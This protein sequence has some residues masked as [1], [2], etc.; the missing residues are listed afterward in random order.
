MND[1]QVRFVYF[2]LSPLS[3]SFSL[4]LSLALKPTPVELLV[5]FR[6]MTILQYIGLEFLKRIKG[7]KERKERERE[8]DSLSLSLFFLFSLF[9]CGGVENRCIIKS[10]LRVKCKKG[11]K[12]RTKA[13]ARSWMDGWMDGWMDRRFS[14]FLLID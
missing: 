7:T 4:S 2:F 1:A 5:D 6:S 10:T 9:A 14:A 11:K 3:F 8:R 13:S 12:I